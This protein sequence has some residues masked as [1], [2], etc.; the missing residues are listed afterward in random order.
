MANP[1]IDPI[2][3][4]IPSIQPSSGG[5][6]LISLVW[7]L[8][9]LSRYSWWTFC[10]ALARWSSRGPRGFPQRAE[11]PNSFEK[12]PPQFGQILVVLW[13]TLLQLLQYAILPSNRAISKYSLTIRIDI[14]K[15]NPSLGMPIAKDPLSDFPKFF[16]VIWKHLNLPDPSLMIIN[17]HVVNR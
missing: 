7:P 13:T 4:I 15:A 17:H 16:F 3:P 10:L 12:S 14:L 8:A 6:W 9:F 5:F 11:G 2:I 1:R